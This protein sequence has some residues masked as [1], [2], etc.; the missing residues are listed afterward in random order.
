MMRVEVSRTD[1]QLSLK[2]VVWILRLSVEGK[3]MLVNGARVHVHVPVHKLHV[4]VHVGGSTTGHACAHTRINLCE[5]AHTHAYKHTHTH[6]HL[7]EVT[8][9]WHVQ[10]DL[11]MRCV[12]LHTCLLYSTNHQGISKFGAKWHGTF[13]ATALVW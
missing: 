11:V 2:G 4:H 6:N 13:E 12:Y 9:E 1:V 5:H 10:E 3:T 7:L 8:R